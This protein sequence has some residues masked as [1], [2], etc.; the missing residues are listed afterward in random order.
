M[1]LLFYV[2]SLLDYV[3]PMQNLMMAHT[4]LTFRINRDVEVLSGLVG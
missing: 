4:Y 3:K 1:P 2:A